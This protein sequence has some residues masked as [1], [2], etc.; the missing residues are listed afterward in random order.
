LWLFLSQFFCR[1]CFIFGG[2]A[3]IVFLAAVAFSLV[4][5]QLYPSFSALFFI[6]LSFAVAA[7]L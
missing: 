4:G 2:S 5:L 3:L 1:R 6:S 7:F